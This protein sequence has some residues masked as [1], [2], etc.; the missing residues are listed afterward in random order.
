MTIPDKSLEYLISNKKVELS[1]Y[2]IGEINSA[3]KCTG[4]AHQ[5]KN[6][7][8]GSIQFSVGFFSLHPLTKFL[9]TTL[10][11]TST[12]TESCDNFNVHILMI[13]QKYIESVSKLNRT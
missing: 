3:Y 12:G 7:Y 1:L 4:K 8:W 10:T 9:L 5:G 11:V 2:D 13:V 6:S